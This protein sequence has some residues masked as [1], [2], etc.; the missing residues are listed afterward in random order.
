MWSNGHR[1]LEGVMTV[2]H[3]LEINHRITQ[4]QMIEALANARHL[5]RSLIMAAVAAARQKQKAGTPRKKSVRAWRL[6]HILL[7]HV[8]T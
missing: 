3:V 2:W 1:G 4:R 7:T 8:H 6:T 5:L